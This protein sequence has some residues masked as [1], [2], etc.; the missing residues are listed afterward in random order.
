MQ[1]PTD[2]RADLPVTVI[3]TSPPANPVASS[4]ATSGVTYIVGTLMASCRTTRD[5]QQ[6]GRS[7][8]SGMVPLQ[9]KVQAPTKRTVGDAQVWLHDGWVVQHHGTG[10]GNCQGCTLGQD[11]V[12][13]RPQACTRATCGRIMQSVAHFKPDTRSMG[14][15]T[16]MLTDKLADGHCATSS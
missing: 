12:H 10:L 7:L 9:L 2:V 6:S 1:V 5:R 4:L 14:C 11:K 13:G 8:A 16:S 15:A 3:V